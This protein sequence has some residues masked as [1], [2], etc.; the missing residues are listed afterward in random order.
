MSEEI[1]TLN[2]DS[3]D[4]SELARVFKEAGRVH[5]PEFLDPESALRIYRTLADQ[6]EWNLAWNDRGKHTDLS[7]TGVLDW[8]TEQRDSLEERIHAQA[9]TAFEY[10]YAAIPIYDIYRNKQMPGHFFNQIYELFMRP[11][12]IDF[13]GHITGDSSIAYADMQATRY[14]R[15]HFLNEHDDNIEGKN[16]V[17]AYVLN[18]TPEWRRD[19]GGALVFTDQNGKSGSC[20]FPTYN[21]LNIFSVPQKHSVS[22]VTP[23]AGAHRYSITGWF[24]Y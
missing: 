4:K 19:W 11:S 2:I 21:A 5:I 12:L 7:Y 3:A 22:F 6:E 14:S 18:L 17:A 13:V 15:G 24:R 9:E 8:T 20:F 16:R 1:L 23:F 10:C